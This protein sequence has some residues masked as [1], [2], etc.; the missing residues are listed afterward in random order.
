MD[1]NRRDYGLRL[2]PPV[3]EIGILELGESSVNFFVRPGVKA[4]DYW[5]V[6]CDLLEKVKLTF[7]DE[8][9]SIPFPQRDI[10]LYQATAVQAPS[11]AFPSAG[12]STVWCAC[13]CRYAF[14]WK[15]HLTGSIDYYYL[16]VTGKEIGRKLGFSSIPCLGEINPHLTNF[17]PDDGN[18]IDESRCFSV[19]QLRGY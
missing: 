16:I 4:S 7:D 11:L 19:K 6:K 17:D 13:G 14:F 1:D 12:R 18:P 3:P 2:R 5:P 8:G 9:I 10:H 15:C